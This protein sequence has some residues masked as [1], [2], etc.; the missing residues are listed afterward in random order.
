MKPEIMPRCRSETRHVGKVGQ[1]GL[2]AEQPYGPGNVA[3][4]RY[5]V[6][7]PST[8]RLDDP[9]AV[10]IAGRHGKTSRLLESISWQHVRHHFASASP[11]LQTARFP[12]P[13]TP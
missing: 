7:P 4:V 3:A 2:G 12:V 1:A 9:L 10:M 8:D 6:Q 5:S 11:D 13:L